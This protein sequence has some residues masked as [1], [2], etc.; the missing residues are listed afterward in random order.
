MRDAAH[1]RESHA[2]HHG[3]RRGDNVLRDRLLT[4]DDGGT[5]RTDRSVGRIEVSEIVRRVHEDAGLRWLAQARTDLQFLTRECGVRRTARKEAVPIVRS[6]LPRFVEDEGGDA[7]SAVRLVDGGS[8][9]HVSLDAGVHEQILVL[10]RHLH[11]DEVYGWI[12][13][14]VGGGLSVRGHVRP[15]AEVP[16]DADDRGG[17]VRSRREYARENRHDDH[18]CHDRC[19]PDH[20]AGPVWLGWDPR[21]PLPTPSSVCKSVS[22]DQAVRG[23]ATEREA[24]YG[25]SCQSIYATLGQ[26]VDP[27]VRAPVRPSAP[28]AV[29]PAVRATGSGW[30]RSR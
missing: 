11:C 17:G 19:D 27:A 25:A 22:I 20:G 6:E 18:E 15:I 9:E 24:V 21:G 28:G 26:P 30:S 12:W 23:A 5:R 3:L 2:E 10:R 16:I 8:L 7:M 1:G 4:D 14:H 29:H 13:R